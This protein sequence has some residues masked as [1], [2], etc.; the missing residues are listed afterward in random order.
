M[1]D[2]RHHDGQDISVFN[3][4]STV[5]VKFALIAADGKV[6]EPVATAVRLT[7][8]RGVSTTLPIDESVYN[9][10]PDAG[11]VY[12]LADG[13]WQYNW[14][15]DKSQAEHYWRVGVRLDDDSTRHVHI[16]LR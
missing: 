2:T 5:P 8:T 14:K 1:N 3:A 7:P 9:D 4:G 12:R 6:V 16:A 10:A 15:T 13:Q 11:S